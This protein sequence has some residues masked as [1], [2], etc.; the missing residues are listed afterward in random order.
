MVVMGED[1]NSKDG[2]K[3]SYEIWNLGLGDEED[4]EDMTKHAE[5]EHDNEETYDED[6]TDHVDNGDKDKLEKPYE[7]WDLGLKIVFSSYII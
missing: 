6:G 7:L 1:G 2:I 5:K 4:E 3:K